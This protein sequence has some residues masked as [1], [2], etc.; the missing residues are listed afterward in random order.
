MAAVVMVMGD[1]GRSPRMMNHA[2]MLLAHTPYDVHILA[3][4][5]TPHPESPMYE[6]LESSP[7]VHLHPISPPGMQFLASKLFLL[8]ALLRVVFQSVQILVELLRISHVQ[9]AVVQV[10]CM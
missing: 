2:T 7:R 9:L 1:I 5:G 8:Y 3:Y 10:A 4:R 6:E